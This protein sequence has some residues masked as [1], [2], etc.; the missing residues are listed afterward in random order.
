VTRRRALTD[1]HRPAGLVMA[2]VAA[3][4]LLGGCSAVSVPTPRPSPPPAP[5]ALA[6]LSPEAAAIPRLRLQL[7]GRIEMLSGY[8]PSWPSSFASD[9]RQ[10]LS[11]APHFRLER[12]ETYDIALSYQATDPVLGWLPPDF[13]LIGGSAPVRTTDGF[14]PE[15]PTSAFVRADAL[16]DFEAG[17][18]GVRVES[19]AGP[20]IYAYPV[21]IEE[22]DIIAADG[23]AGLLVGITDEDGAA[24][25]T[26]FIAHLR[27]DLQRGG[28]PEPV[29]YA[30]KA[31]L[32][33]AF[34]KGDLDAY[35]AIPKGWSD[36]PTTRNGFEARSSDPITGN[37]ATDTGD[38]YKLSSL[39]VRALGPA[40]LIVNRGY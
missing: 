31:E 32:V 21:W 11:L 20:R 28:G 19:R 24:A 8:D 25:A 13:G 9:R 27:D 34:E 26:S 2:L 23:F 22:P 10:I 38:S 5:G 30:T 35:I 37:G 12:G 16:P 7:A 33:A 6:T 39:I 4:A 15:R 3:I 14:V 18:F 17:L 1:R 40:G 36:R 29:M